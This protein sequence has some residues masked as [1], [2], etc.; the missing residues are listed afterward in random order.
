MH[1]KTFSEG[2]VFVCDEYTSC[3]KWKSYNCDNLQVA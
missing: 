2:V 1:S 3:L